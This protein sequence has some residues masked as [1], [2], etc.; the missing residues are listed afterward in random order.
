MLTSY[1]SFLKSQAYN[2]FTILR[3]LAKTK[4][5]LINMGKEK[6]LAMACITVALRNNYSVFVATSDED[7]KNALKH[8]FPTVTYPL[9]SLGV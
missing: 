4:S 2:I 6:T 3:G 5:T 7:D 8:A 9:M 1:F